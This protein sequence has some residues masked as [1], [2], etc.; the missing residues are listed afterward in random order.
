MLGAIGGIHR[1]LTLAATGLTMTG[2]SGRITTKTTSAAANVTTSAAFGTTRLH[3]LLPFL[4]LFLIENALE[5]K[6]MADLRLSDHSL[7]FVD[8]CG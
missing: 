8:G 3:T 5:V 7:D 1:E 2:T 6:L 4:K